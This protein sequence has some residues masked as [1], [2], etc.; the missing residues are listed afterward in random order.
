[1]GTLA[2]SAAPRGVIRLKLG[3]HVCVHGDAV[4]VAGA[5]LLRDGKHLLLV[6]NGAVLHRDVRGLRRGHVLLL[7]CRADLWVQGKR[8]AVVGTVV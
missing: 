8:A 5:V 3:A 2:S 1:M 6:C 7:V 4:G